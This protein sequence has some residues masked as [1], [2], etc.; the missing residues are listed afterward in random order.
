MISETEVLKI[1]IER[2]KSAGIPYMVTGSIAANFY[3]TPRMTR[4][5]DIVIEIEESDIERLFSLFSNDFYVDLET[6]KRA[7]NMKRMFNI[8][9]HEGIVKVDFI[10]RKDA[11]Y[12]KVEFGRRQG[13]NFEGLNIYIVSPEDLVLSKLFWAKDNRSEL[14]M[15]DVKNILRTVHHLDIGYIEKWVKDLRLD[16]IYKE[17]RK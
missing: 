9:H 12:R 6:I 15:R 10:I 8:I 14:Q 11:E 13:I 5:I 4:D 2:L 16:E 7:F 1:V 17:V 3:T